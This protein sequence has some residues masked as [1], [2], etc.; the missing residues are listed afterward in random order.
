MS[1]LAWI[2]SV[3]RLIKG[4]LKPFVNLLVNLTNQNENSILNSSKIL[5][6]SH[7]LICNKSSKKLTR[8]I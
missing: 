1:V 4:V 7:K 6:D 2:T 5:F 8:I 3:L